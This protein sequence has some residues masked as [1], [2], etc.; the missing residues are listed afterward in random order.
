MR[1]LIT[2]SFLTFI[3]YSG[4]GQS[5]EIGGSF[6]STF[7]DIQI[8]LNKNKC[9]NC[10][11]QEKS[12][13]N[14][15]YDSYASFTRSGDCNQPI[16]IHGNA[17]D[18]YLYRVV[19]G[20]DNLCSESAPIHKLSESDLDK[21]ETWINQG[22]PESCLPLYPDVRSIF[23]ANN[24]QSC[25][26]TTSGLWRYDSYQD[27]LGINNSNNCPD[28]KIVVIGNAEQSLL[29]DKINNDN[30]V[31]C[32]E[33]MNGEFGPLTKTE[34]S[35][36]RDWINGGAIESAATLPV[37]L[38]YFESEEVDK[39]VRLTWSTE[40]EIG[41]DIFVIE[42]STTGR[43]FIEIADINATGSA[44]SSSQYAYTHK[45]PSSEENY[46]R[47]KIIDLDGSFSYSNIRFTRLD[48]QSTEMTISPN[49]A[50]SSE[51]L[52]VSWYP[53]KGQE[54]AYLNILDPNGRNL[55]RKIIFVG[56]NYVRLPVLLEG[57]Y[58]VLV[59]DYFSGF[60]LERVVIIN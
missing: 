41:T 13:A 21:I 48:V 40:I 53:K 5:C 9:G 29:Y 30:Q 17:S 60:I 25:H 8:L 18:S 59:E 27:L 34:I 57:V 20:T 28:T 24:C 38:S 36:I 39:S 56:T 15:N 54:Q 2:I 47:L 12:S 44:S 16:I 46:Y 52:K 26:S 51:R 35:K 33:S 6:F 3:F 1:N 42:H 45:A 50:M 43:N 31:Y 58:Y 32:G 14:W 11:A 19:S 55:H 23:D 49:P 7:E 37:E 10:H 4:Y 22:A